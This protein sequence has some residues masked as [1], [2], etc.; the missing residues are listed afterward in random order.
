MKEILGFS[1]L[2]TIGGVRTA[3]SL[4]PQESAGPGV[5]AG[6][7]DHGLS[8]PLH[9]VCRW[10]VPRVVCLNLH[11]PPQTSKGAPGPGRPMSFADK[12]LMHPACSVVGLL[13]YGA[14]PSARQRVDAS[15]CG[16]ASRLR[17]VSQ[18]R[19]PTLSPA[20][21]PNQPLHRRSRDRRG[22]WNPLVR[23]TS[24]P[25]PDATWHLANRLPMG[26]TCCPWGAPP[27][28][29]RTARGGPSL[30]R[31]FKSTDGCQ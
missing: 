16:P 21:R 15:T 22:P 10:G 11:T 18:L 19:R 4:I 17:R 23:W 12:T 6:S 9:Q 3:L 24:G 5:C 30:G 27:R 14:P 20:T 1:A 13:S 7:S 31:G 28:V 26:L 29:L 8:S 25:L 2:L